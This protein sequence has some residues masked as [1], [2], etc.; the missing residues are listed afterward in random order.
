[1]EKN[2]SN[3]PQ[4]SLEKL[5]LT[6]MAIVSDLTTDFPRVMQSYRWSKPDRPI[7]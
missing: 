5:G 1:M 3:V 7:F 4:Q 6:S 2:L